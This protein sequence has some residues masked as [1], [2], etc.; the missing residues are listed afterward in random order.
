MDIKTNPQTEIRSSSELKREEGKKPTRSFKE[1]M[2][3]KEL[4]RF[5]GRRKSVFDLAGK[6]KKAPQEKKKLP[7][8]A[9]Q[10]GEIKELSS[11]LISEGMEVSEVDEISLEI[12]ALVDEMAEYVKVESKNGISK[13]TVT[14]GLENSIFNESEIVIDHYDTAPHS[15]N[16]QLLGS[17]EAQQFFISH[18]GSLQSALGA[19]ES[20]KSFQVNLL[21]PALVDKPDLYTRGLSK[22][23]KKKIVKFKSSQKNDFL[24]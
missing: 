12:S 11:S 22:E 8:S 5:N 7:Q 3:H 4:P 1:V 18:L 6:E 16:L 17:P 24:I 13:T 15:F 2:A 19:Y 20:M 21:P 23:K 14:L 9:N 10:H